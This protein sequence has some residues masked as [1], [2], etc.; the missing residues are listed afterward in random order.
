MLNPVLM[1]VSFALLACVA[2]A[3]AAAAPSQPLL[4][5]FVYPDQGGYVVALDDTP[6]LVGPNST[7]VCVAGVST[8]L[9]LRGTKAVSGKDAFG[10]WTGV[11]VSWGGAGNVSAVYTFQSYASRPSTVVATASFPAGLDTSNCGSNT[12]GS[13]AFPA[14]SVNDAQAPTLDFV[15]WR[16]TTAGAAWSSGLSAL[17]NNGIGATYC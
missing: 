12:Q 15:T 13:T 4:S 6:W 1:R 3:L 16:G 8:P 11:S 14:F 9:T 10:P 5:V 2:A 7:S 17:K